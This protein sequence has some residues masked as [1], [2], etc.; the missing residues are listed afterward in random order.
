MLYFKLYLMLI[1]L[2]LLFA[3]YEALFILLNNKLPMALRLFAGL[4]VF[5]I[6]YIGL[7]R[8]TYL[9]FLGPMALPPSLLKDELKPEGAQEV[10]KVPMNE[11]DG[12]KIV[13]WASQKSEKTFE[14]P[15]TAYGEYPNAGITTV[16]DGAVLFTVY[17]PAAYKVPRAL[18]KP[19]IHYRVVYPKGILGEIKTIYVKC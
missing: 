9:P 16:K 10:F 17:C 3:L 8:N 12:T 4:M 15:W 14:D 5:V 18:L 7:Q 6:G 13:Y 2:V 11:E 1:V 19:H